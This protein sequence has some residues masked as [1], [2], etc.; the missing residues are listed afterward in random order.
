MLSSV[1][2]C[3]RLNSRKSGVRKPLICVG[4]TVSKARKFNFLS[5]RRIEEMKNIQLKKRTF[6]KM[7]WGVNAYNEWHKVRLSKEYNENIFNAN[8]EQLGSFTKCELKELL[9][10][11]IPEVTK[12]KG[13]GDYPSKTLYEMIVSIQKYLNVNKIK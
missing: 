8:L 4:K 7:S 13:H 5:G 12:S 3:F 11:F 6:S 9:C 2:Y 10:Y 1:N